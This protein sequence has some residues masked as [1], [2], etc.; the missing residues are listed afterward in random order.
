MK[1]T[2]IARKKLIADMLP[3]LRDVPVKISTQKEMMLGSELLALGTT[4]SRSGEP[5]VRSREYETFT[6][7][8]GLVNHSNKIEKIIKDAKTEEQLENDL[9]L[10]LTKNAKSLEAVKS[11]E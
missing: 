8:M 5:I 6:P 3:M 11:G 4:H 2:V 1:Y 9:A 10:Y 7:I